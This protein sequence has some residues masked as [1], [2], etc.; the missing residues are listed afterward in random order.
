[1]ATSKPSTRLPD[2]EKYDPEHEARGDTI[3]GTL[4]AEL[5]ATTPPEPGDF[6]PTASAPSPYRNPASIGLN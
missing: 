3:T 2:K 4:P 5:E 6:G 1:M